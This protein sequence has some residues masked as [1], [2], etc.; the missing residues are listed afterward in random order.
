MYFLAHSVVS[1]QPGLGLREDSEMVIQGT[2]WGCNGV[3]CSVRH[4]SWGSLTGY[5]D[6]LCCVPGFLVLGAH[7]P[8]ESFW[9]FSH[10]GGT[11]VG[12]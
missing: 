12:V 6:P 3:R 2:F 5:L 9:E 10:G 8:F 11:G 7:C 4:A 1:P